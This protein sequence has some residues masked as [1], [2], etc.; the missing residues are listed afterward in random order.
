[1]CCCPALIAGVLSRSSF[2]NSALVA[3][4]SAELE[5]INYDSPSALNY[6]FQE[7]LFRHF[8]TSSARLAR[9]DVDD[10][11]HK[12]LSI[13]DRKS[14][15]VKS[16]CMMQQNNSQKFRSNFSIRKSNHLAFRQPISSIFDDNKSFADI[17][18]ILSTAKMFL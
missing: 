9:D 17:L 11:V 10:E 18:C 7:N 13:V 6:E 3:T 1:M 16:A 2:I 12:H 15:D 4:F 8:C 14:Y 5:P